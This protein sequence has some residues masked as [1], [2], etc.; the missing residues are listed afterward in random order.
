MDKIILTSVI[1]LIPIF[2]CSVHAQRTGSKLDQIELMKQFEGKFKS[3]SGKDT[4]IY[5]DFK[6]FGNNGYELYYSFTYKGKTFFGVRDLWGYDSKTDRWICFSLQT[7]EEYKLFYGK[8]ISYNKM[9]I[10]KFS[11]NGKVDKPECYIQEVI[12][13]DDFI[14]Y[15]NAE[16]T[17]QVL[18]KMERMK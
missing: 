2:S 9:V 3:E 4:I 16:G 6:P 7:V 15:P 14:G 11:I 18:F 1:L 10:E 12:S 17:K 8:F 13:E 5:W